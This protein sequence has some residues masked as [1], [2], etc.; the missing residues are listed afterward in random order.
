[1]H[2]VIH[3]TTKT[4][5]L[6]TYRNVPYAPKTFSLVPSLRFGMTITLTVKCRCPT[7]FTS[8]F[9]VW[10]RCRGISFPHFIAR[11]S[12]SQSIGK[13]DSESF[14]RPCL[15]RFLLRE[16]CFGNRLL[17]TVSGI[18]SRPCLSRFLLRETCFGNRFLLYFLTL[19]TF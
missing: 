4:T 14:S 3:L 8:S 6:P 12:L 5:E 10:Q 9:F 15:S 1:M 19:Q 16:T 11:P 17:I 18:F 2:R 7:I 13:L